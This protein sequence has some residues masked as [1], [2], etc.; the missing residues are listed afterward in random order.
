MEMD[1]KANDKTQSKK[2]TWRQIGRQIIKAQ[3][4]MEFHR[5]DTHMRLMNRKCFWT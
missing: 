4:R 2:E 5:K 1:R 3:S